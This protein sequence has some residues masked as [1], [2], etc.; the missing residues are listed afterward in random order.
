LKSDAYTNEFLKV[1][2]IHRLKALYHAII[3]RAVFGFVSGAPLHPVE[4]AMPPAM[5]ESFFS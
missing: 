3:A 1:D 5:I 4:S 2:L